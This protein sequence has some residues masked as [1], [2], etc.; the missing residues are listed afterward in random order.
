MKR[1]VEVVR[2]EHSFTCEFL[3][4]NIQ[5]LKNKISVLE[6]F[7]SNIKN[8]YFICITE[9]WL[10][11][12]EISVCSPNGYYCASA[13]CRIDHIRGGSLIY[14]H[15]KFQSRP[16]DVTCFYIEFH[17]E[18]TAVFIDELKLIVTTIYHSTAGDPIIFLETLEK[19][20]LY[21]SQ[22]PSYN[23]VITGDLN[24]NFDIT[25]GKKT[26]KTFINLL[27]QNNFYCYNYN[28]TRGSN[29]LDNLFTNYPQSQVKS[30]NIF[31]FPFSDHDGLIVNIKLSLKTNDNIYINNNN[32]KSLSPDQYIF[33]PKSKYY[34]I[35]EKLLSIDWDHSF[36]QKIATST[37]STNCFDLLFYMIKNCVDFFSVIKTIEPRKKKSVKINKFT[38]KCKWYTDELGIMKTKLLKLNSLIKELKEPGIVLRGKYITLKKQYKEGIKTAKMAYNANYIESSNNKCR[39]AWNVIKKLN[40]NLPQR[41]SHQISPDEFNNFFVNSILNIKKKVQSTSA[42]TN[43]FAQKNAPVLVNFKFRPVEPNE[44]I[45][46]ANRLSNSDSKDVYNMSNNLIK[47]IIHSIAKPLTFCINNFLQ[48]GTFPDVLKISRIC[49]VFKRGQMDYPGNYRP[50]AIIPV[51]SKLVEILVHNQVSKYFEDNNLFDPNQFGFRKN[52]STLNAMDQLTRFVF[53]SF[54]RKD[55]AQATLCDLSNAFDCV[56]HDDLLNKLSYYGVKDAALNFFESYLL[57]RKQ[58]VFINGQW[59]QEVSVDFGVPQGSVLGPFLFLV[60]INDLST[61]VGSTTILYADDTT[62]LNTNNDFNSLKKLNTE[63]LLAASNWFESNGFLLNEAKTQSICFRLRPLPQ[64]QILQNHLESVKFLGIYFDSTLTWGHHID[65]ITPRLSRTIYL[66]RRLTHC[67]KYDY[68]RT[69]YFAYFQSIIRY[70]L[71]LWGNCSR[72]EEVL[73]LQK[74]AVRILTNSDPLAHCKPLFIKTKIQTVIN[75]FIFDLANYALNS[76]QFLKYSEHKYTTRHKDKAVIDYH[77]LSKLTNSHIVLSLKVYNKLINGI[78]RH[79]GKTLKNKLYDWLLDNPFYDIN[80]FFSTNIEF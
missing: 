65:Y 13:S 29:C 41:N 8:L 48:N 68:V 58:K 52:I 76:P 17:F 50:I 6:S 31:K 18:V 7:I 20:L 14:V 55:F 39:A 27:R 69:A 33:L 36:F 38:P 77:R 21:L 9:H 42:N 75:L 80:D 5:G 34:L 49:P 3:S 43:N 79:G 78:S 57:N 16:L 66:L 56:D 71:L 25:K 15:S 28:P 1:G 46:A 61:S 40:N 32:Y 2:L 4:L 73:L 64:N 54:E 60:D 53:S 67:V 35:N 47:C 63:T 45:D 37:N 59:S 51:I 74:K 22:W 70:G 62:F 23:S 12:N 10:T 11:Q 24:Y 44:L 26:V 19:Y 72:I 30:C